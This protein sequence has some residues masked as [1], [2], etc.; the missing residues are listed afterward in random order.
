[1]KAEPGTQTSVA[2]E[3]GRLRRQT[4]RPAVGL[5]ARPPTDA[6]L[7]VDGR[8]WRRSDPKMP[9]SLRQELVDELMSARRAVAAAADA[10]QRRAARQRVQDAK[11]ALGER[12]RPWWLDATATDLEPRIDAAMR[13]LLRSRQAGAT[14]CPSEPA[15]I[16]DGESWRRLLP[17]VRARAMALARAGQVVIMRK[18]QPASGDLTKGVLRYRL[19]DGTA[20]RGAS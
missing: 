4:G 6:F 9:A 12:G 14:I 19:V 18:R 16:A 2:D 7:E 11:V 13:A 8:K 10:R 3:A 15:R 5:R 1:M 20:R 17:T